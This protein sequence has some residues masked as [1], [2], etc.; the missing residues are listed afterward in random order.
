LTAGPGPNTQISET[1]K[2]RQ[3]PL[4]ARL[5]TLKRGMQPKKH[6]NIAVNKG[7]TGPEVNRRLNYKRFSIR[8][9]V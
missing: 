6:E 3:K 5:P 4:A 8:A 7:K 9:R 1:S 2:I